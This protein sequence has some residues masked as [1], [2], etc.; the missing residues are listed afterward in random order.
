MS[1]WVLLHVFINGILETSL[2]WGEVDFDL[3]GIRLRTELFSAVCD[4]V[5]VECVRLLL[6]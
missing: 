2:G 5:V 6:V 4:V 3:S 1:L